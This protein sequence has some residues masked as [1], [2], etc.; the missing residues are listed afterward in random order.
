MSIKRN[1]IHKD[2][3]VKGFILKIFFKFHSEKKLRTISKMAR[4]F[5]N[6][7]LS[8]NLNCSEQ[9]ITTRNGST[10]RLCIYKPLN[11][12]ND[13]AG[14]LWIHGG[15]YAM[16][17]PEMDLKYYENFINTANCVIVAP[18]YTLSYEKPYP[19]AF[20]DCYEALLWLKDNAASLGVREDQLF[21]M[22][23]SAGGGLTAAVTLCARDKGEVNVAFQM[24]LYPMLD[25]RMETDSAKDNKTPVWDSRNNE[26]A[27]RMYLSSLFKTEEVP[28]YAAPAR[29]TDYSGLPSTYTFIGDIEPFYDETVRYIDN[30]KK[31]GV[32]AE[33]D[34]YNGCFHAFDTY[35]T[36]IS[37]KATQKMLDVFLY[38]TQNYFAGQ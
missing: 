7:K 34:I 3:R 25:D 16:G 36:K 1:M 5:F 23:D 19:A 12:K 22:G 35:N 9:I 26:T 33:I 10:L 30:L 8:K 18:D 14:V 32:H 20:D 38:A 31:A 29:E 21:V 24:P 6:G 15:G 2:L 13:A 4:K 17:A 28:K 27:W 11:Q 37:K